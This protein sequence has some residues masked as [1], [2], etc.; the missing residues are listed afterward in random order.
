MSEEMGGRAEIPAAEWRRGYVYR[1]ELGSREL[2]PA[3][4]AA[5][6]VAVAVFYVTKLL[7]ERTP[8]DP[9]HPRPRVVPNPLERR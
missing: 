1:R 5:I 9:P 2:L 6:A 4:G 8:L 3:V 7:I